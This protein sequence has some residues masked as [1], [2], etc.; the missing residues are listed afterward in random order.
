MR[1]LPEALPLALVALGDT[2]TLDLTELLGPARRWRTRT[3][4]GLT[5]HP[6]RRGGKTVDGLEDQY[7]ASSP[8]A[9]FPTPTASGRSVVH[10]SNTGAHDPASRAL[11]LRMP[12]VS[13]SS[14]TCSEAHSLSAPSATSDSGCS[15]LTS[16]ER[17]PRSHP[18]PHAER[19]CVLP[20]DS[21]TSSGLTRASRTAPTPPKARFVHRTRATSSAAACPQPDQLGRAETP[22]APSLTMSSERLGL[23]AKVDLLES[24]RATASCRS[25]TNTGRPS[26]RAATLGAGADTAL[27]P[28]PLFCGSRLPRRSRRGLL[29][30]RPALATASRSPPARRA[31]RSPPLAE[32]RANAARDQAPPPLVDSPKCPRCS[33]VGTLPP[34][35]VNLLS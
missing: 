26:Q 33:L 13:N 15:S 17:E 9:D 25:S 11:R 32:L 22:R 24:Q 30:P 12:S 2:D 10:G 6:K 20:E 23:I 14:S 19:A 16:V 1:G 7:A 18:C 8:R 4:F 31:E 5:R 28:G 29:L 3:P 21:H 35:E 27:R 34:D